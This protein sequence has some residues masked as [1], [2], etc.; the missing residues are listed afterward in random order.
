MFYKNTKLK[1]LRT[2]RTEFRTCLKHPKHI[3]TW[4]WR[5]QNECTRI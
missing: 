5:R 3:S 4:V 2:S 1:E